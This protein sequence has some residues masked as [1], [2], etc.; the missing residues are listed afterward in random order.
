MSALALISG[1]LFRRPEERMSKSGRPFVTTTLK[2]AAGGAV[3]FWSVVAFSQTAQAE[4]K[5]LEEGDAASI[6]GA[7]KVETFSKNGDTKLSYSIV[8]DQVLALRQ[9]PKQRHAKEAMPRSQPASVGAA[10]FNDD[11]AF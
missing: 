1:V 6:Q 3:E 5:R 11:I 9:P 2:V 8:A 4:A 10:P 7:F